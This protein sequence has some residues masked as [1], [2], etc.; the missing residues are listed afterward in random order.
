MVPLLELMGL[1][2]YPSVMDNGNYF[3]IEELIPKDN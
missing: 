2:M 1:L 3:H